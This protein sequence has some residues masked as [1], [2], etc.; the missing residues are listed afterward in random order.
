MQHDKRYWHFRLLLG[1]IE[2]SDVV[3]CCFA[4]QESAA[5]R[6][7]E[8]NKGAYASALLSGSQF[9]LRRVDGNHPPG[10]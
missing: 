7:P 2:E 8:S 6:N 5:Q 9:A 3:S 10:I 4:V 1:I